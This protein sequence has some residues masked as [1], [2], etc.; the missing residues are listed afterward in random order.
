MRADKRRRGTM[1]NQAE[2]ITMQQSLT[3]LREVIPASAKGA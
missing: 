1:A 3:A 2:R